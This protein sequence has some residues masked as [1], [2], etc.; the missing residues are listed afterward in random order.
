MKRGPPKTP[1][2]TRNRANPPPLILS[3]ATTKSSKKGA[4][5][6]EPANL[7]NNAAVAAKAKTNAQVI[8]KK[9]AE[10]KKRSINKVLALDED[11]QREAD[12][13]PMKVAKSPKPAPARPVPAKP[14]AKPPAK[15]KIV[16]E[17]DGGGDPP[18]RAPEDDSIESESE[19]V[20]GSNS[21]LGRRALREL[22]AT[23][24][25]RRAFAPSALRR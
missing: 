2:K 25:N 1:P 16:P 8:S 15:E 6:I 14:K 18:A 7:C 21:G 17:P 4:P 20:S 23:Q 9:R 5:I 24:E 19:Y 11:D 22:G 3:N 13:L 12:E 10:Q